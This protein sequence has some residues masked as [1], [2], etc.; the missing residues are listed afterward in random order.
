MALRPPSPLPLARPNITITVRPPPGGSAQAPKSRSKPFIDIK[1]GFKQALKQSTAVGQV[2]ALMNQYKSIHSLKD[3]VGAIKSTVGLAK[4]FGLLGSTGKS[5]ASVSKVSY[6]GDYFNKGANPAIEQQKTN[7][8]SFS[9]DRLIAKVKVNGLAKSNKFMIEIVPPDALK[10]R[11]D[12]FKELSYMCEQVEFPGRTVNTTDAR[13]YGP[14]FKMPNISQYQ[15]I[16]ITVLCDK[17]LREKRI[18]DE[19]MSLINPT[20]TFDFRYRKD[21]STSVKVYQYSDD[22]DQTYAVELY[23][24]YPIAVAPLQANHNDDQFHKVQVTLC[25]WFWKEIP[26]TPPVEKLPNKPLPSW[27]PPKLEDRT[28]TANIDGRDYTVTKDIDKFHKKIT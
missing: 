9:I 16:N 6:G 2:K 18:F 7:T 10:Q 25:Y 5:R 19:W 20:D 23:M 27:S 14:T 17:Y 3:A 28:R 11:T 13:I 15:E 12:T 21:Y 1:G 4:K 8:V 24:A 26:T 22:G